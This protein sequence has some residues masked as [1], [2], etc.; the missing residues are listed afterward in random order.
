MIMEL[1]EELAEADLDYIEGRVYTHED[2]MRA[3]K[4]KYK[5]LNI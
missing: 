3:L 2:V 5:K 4:M 1:K